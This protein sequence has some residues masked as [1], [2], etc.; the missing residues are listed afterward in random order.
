MNVLYILLPLALILVTAAIL[1]YRWATKEGQ[2]D[3]LETPAV[4][5]VLD[6]TARASDQM[7]GDRDTGSTDS[8][9]V[10]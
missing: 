3:D 5:A 6:D 1:A 8:E 10:S 2:F 7:A 4:R 9:E